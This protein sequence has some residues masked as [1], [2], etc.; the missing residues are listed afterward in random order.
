MTPSTADVTRAASA[1]S[2][3]DRSRACCA[4]FAI[5]ARE[6]SAA[7]P[8]HAASLECLIRPAK[9]LTAEL[10]RCAISEYSIAPLC[11]SSVTNGLNES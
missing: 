4:Y 7:N 1:F 3:C 8:S 5:A 6:A 9:K 10:H 2:G 11:A